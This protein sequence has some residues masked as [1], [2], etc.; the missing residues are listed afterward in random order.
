MSEQSMRNNLTKAAGTGIRN[1]KKACFYIK[2]LHKE[3]GRSEQF[4]LASMVVNAVE[5]SNDYQEFRDD[6]MAAWK[7]EESRTI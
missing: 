2:R 6:L 1:A 4:I 7:E 3:T 5:S